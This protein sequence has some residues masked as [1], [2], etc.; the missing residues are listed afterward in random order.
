M[1]PADATRAADASAPAGVAVVGR[2]RAATSLLDPMRRRILEAL[3][4]PA[5]ATAVA[6]SFGL[7]RQVVNY[8][9]R[10]LEKAGLVEEVGRRQRRGLE[11]RIVRATATSYLISPEILGSLGQTPTERADRFSATYQVAVAARTIREVAELAALARSAGKRLTTL[12]IDTEIR[13]ASPAD[14]QAFANDLTELTQQLVAK[15]H[16]AST[17]NGRVYRLFIGA[18]PLG[19]PRPDPEHTRRRRTP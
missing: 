18:H 9:V 14:R 12:T 4:E 6:G 11:E 16:D 2:D 7:S 19:A 15:Y 17:A 8:H 3:Q 13:F 1:E 10:A 5:S